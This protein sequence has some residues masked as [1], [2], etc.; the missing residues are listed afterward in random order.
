MKISK[1]IRSPKEL[2]FTI[3]IRGGLKFL[4]DYA[5]VRLLFFCRF[6][7]KPNLSHPV[8]FN[9]K[10]QWLKLNNYKDIYARMVDKHEA[11]EYVAGII[12]SEYTIPTLG[13]WDSFKDI[14]F[15]QLPRQFVLKCTHDSG[16]VVIC[17]DKEQF[18]KKHARKKLE[19]SL[20]KNYYWSGRELPYR[21]VK[22]RIIAEEYLEEK[23][24]PAPSAESASPSGIRD[25]KF[26]CFHGKVKYL[27]ISEGL[28]NHSTARISFLTE[29]WEPADFHRTDYA[30]F[31]HLPEKPREFERMKVLAEK[32]SGGEPFMRV[33]LYSVN[34][35]IY[36]SELT[37]VPCSGFM[38][39]CP[40][41]W[42][43]RLGSLL[44][45]GTDEN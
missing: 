43:N 6:G 1:Y 10:L 20:K 8:T 9:E 41:E 7:R 39:F 15:E 2:I 24:A 26:Y 38:P 35:R 23:S 28:E 16:G 21:Y 34:G 44:S 45:V 12:G 36:F 19:A 25:Y 22:P 31:D 32:L 3:G 40:S 37:L 18:D 17:R 13:V 14:D 42:D 33:D 11:K 30:P 27:Y 4:S 29:N 5:Y